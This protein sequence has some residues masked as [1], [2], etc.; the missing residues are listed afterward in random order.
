MN[1]S[2]NIQ[3]KEKEKEKEISDIKRNYNKIIEELQ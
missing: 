3:E 1:E 2:N